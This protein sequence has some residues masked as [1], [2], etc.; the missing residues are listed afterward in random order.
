MRGDWNYWKPTIIPVHNN[1]L[2]SSA[3][4]PKETEL[5]KTSIFNYA[6]IHSMV[7]LSYFCL[8]LVPFPP[9]NIFFGY[10]NFSNFCSARDINFTEKPRNKLCL[11]WNCLK[12]S[13]LTLKRVEESSEVKPILISGNQT[14]EKWAVK[15]SDS[16]WLRSNEKGKHIESRSRHRLPRTN[17]ETWLAFTRV[18]LWRPKLK[19]VRVCS[20]LHWSARGV[21]VSTLAGARNLRKTQPCSVGA[22]EPSDKYRVGWTTQSFS[23]WP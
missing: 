3:C 14:W 4:R 11:H 20:R 15:E 17:I 10:L 9:Q 18:K 16:S 6:T 8:P 12:I 2:C 7:L 5:D 23:F 13:Q 22:R 1:I 21:S 19:E